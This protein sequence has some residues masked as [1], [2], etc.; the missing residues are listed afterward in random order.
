MVYND[1][2][3]A[4]RSADHNE[5]PA[6][7]RFCDAAPRFSDSTGVADAATGV[8]VADQWYRFGGEAG[9]EMATT[10]PQLYSC[11]TYIPGWFAGEIPKH[12]FATEVGDACFAMSHDDCVTS[13]QVSVT[14]CDGFLVYQLPNVPFCNMGYCG[15]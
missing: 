5:G 12:V 8:F 10:P 11:G 9:T 15:Q 2:V 13:V 6:G 1:L 14:R 4:R 7:E 3:A